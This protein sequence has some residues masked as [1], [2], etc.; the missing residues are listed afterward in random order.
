MK[1]IVKIS[2]ILMVILLTACSKTTKGIGIHHVTIEIENYGNIEVEL[3]GDKAPITVENFLKLVDQNFYDGLS[4]HRI[5]KGFMM[6]GG[7]PTIMDRKKSESIK[8]EFAENGITNNISH[9][10][11]VI[12]MARTTDKNSASSQFFIMHVT[13]KTLD[14][15]YA[16]F[17]K[18]TKGM[19]VVDK[20]C[21]SVQVEDN[22]GTVLKENQPI[23][24]TITKID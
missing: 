13:N 21:E 19:F 16:A 3:D 7:D 14:G 5:M 4:F 24:K 18:V 12:S 6:Q 1:K 9:E 23:I 8:G 11:G 15:K 10:R 22:N 2:L 20:I 17:G